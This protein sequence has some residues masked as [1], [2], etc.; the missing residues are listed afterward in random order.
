M[1]PELEF[2]ISTKTF[3]H[4][5][6]K[7]AVRAYVQAS[8]RIRTVSLEPMMFVHISDEPKGNLSQRIR[9]VAHLRGWH[10]Q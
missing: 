10:A 3:E 5:H 8:L 2:A 7:Q 1:I 6:D 9:H 4:L